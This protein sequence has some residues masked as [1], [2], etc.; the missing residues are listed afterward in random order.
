MT[1]HCCCVWSRIWK[2]ILFFRDSIKVNKCVRA[3][4]VSSKINRSLR[5]PKSRISFPPLW[6]PIADSAFGKK[7]M[8][9]GR[10]CPKTNLRTKIHGISL[11]D[12][13][14]PKP[15]L[16][17]ARQNDVASISPGPTVKSAKIFNAK[18]IV[19]VLSDA[20]GYDLSHQ[21]DEFSNS[22]RICQLFECSLDMLVSSIP[23]THIYIYI[24]ICTVYGI[25][26]CV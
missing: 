26:V 13:L 16:T 21:R 5:Y 22:W 25:N 11:S 19:L 1:S 12:F 17:P 2:I 4:K 9:E 20:S 23:G 15:P 8:L 14:R 7:Q 10:M 6:Y 3:F 18:K 24:C